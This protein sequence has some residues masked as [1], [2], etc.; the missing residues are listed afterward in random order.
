MAHQI[1]RT[2]GK[3]EMAYFGQVPWHGLG[4]AFD[5]PM[6]SREAIE[7]AGL[8]W[9]VATRPVYL[10]ARDPVG[11]FNEVPLFRATVRTD[12]DAVLGMV[13]A[14]FVPLQNVEAFGWFDGVVGEGHAAYHTAGSLRGGSRVWILAKLPDSQ[15]IL[16][17]D[18]IDQ[19]LLLSNGHDGGQG[20]TVGFTPIRVVCANTLAGAV[21]QEKAERA[22][23]KDLVEVMH[24][25]G[26]RARLTDGLRV[27]GAAR[28]YFERFGEKARML[29]TKTLTDEVARQYFEA[30]L[31]C[32]KGHD[33]TTGQVD[34][35]KTVQTVLAGLFHEGRHNI[36]PGMQGTAWAGYNAVTEY[37]GHLVRR[38]SAES[39]FHAMVYGDGAALSS[40]AFELALELAEK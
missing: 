22:K 17:D 20:I 33:I 23:K 24:T 31:P 25:I 32:P 36:L 27:I 29:T 26:A 19:Y 15:W 6:T 4:T 9:T 12:T 21:P 3:D 35:W 34:G 18:K 7:A 1:T 13:T 2:N 40:R 11:G 39:R 30:V 10:P 16:P 37:A 5:R 8:G 28:K 38:R 14:R